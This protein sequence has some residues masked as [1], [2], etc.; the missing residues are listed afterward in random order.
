MLKQG[1]VKMHLNQILIYGQPS[2]KNIKCA[3]TN[4]MILNTGR[5]PDSYYNG[6]V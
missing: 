3:Q 1:S 5:L 2:K 4:I 6:S